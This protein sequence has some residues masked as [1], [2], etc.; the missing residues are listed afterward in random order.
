MKAWLEPSLAGTVA[1]VI[2]AVAYGVESPSDTFSIL[3]GFAAAVFAAS[4]LGVLY[5][6]Q[7][8]GWR[9]VHVAFVWCSLMCLL[10]TALLL[11]R[12]GYAFSSPFG[13]INVIWLLSSLGAFASGIF[14]VLLQLANLFRDEPVPEHEWAV[15]M[16]PIV[17]ELHATVRDFYEAV[18]RQRTDLENAA[19]RMRKRVE[20]QK[21]EM[22]KVQRELADARSEIE[23]HEA[24]GKLTPEQQQALIRAVP[25]TGRL[26]QN[27]WVGVGSGLS[28][29][30]AI[31]LL[32]HGV[33]LF[34]EFAR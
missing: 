6:Q 2:S 1:V 27:Y 12:T 20:L 28:V 19:S 34:V 3:S 4:V 16:K 15:D 33:G 13:A 10:A 8:P 30:L 17:T 26:R 23:R 5:R 24:I 11:G 9:R 25:R 21:E 29:A 14:V 32:R 7:L 18:S 31:E 22:K